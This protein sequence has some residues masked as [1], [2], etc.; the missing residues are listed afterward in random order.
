MDQRMNHKENWGKT[1]LNDKKHKM[2]QYIQN[3][4]KILLRGNCMALS[5]Y[6]RR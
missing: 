3:I 5:A 6:I 4:A 1:E 2:Y